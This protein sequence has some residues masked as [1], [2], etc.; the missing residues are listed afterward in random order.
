MIA[1]AI[2]LIVHTV[3]LSDGSRKITQ[4]T[5]VAEMLDEIHINLKDIFI[6]KQTGIDSE[7][8][9]LG[10]FRPTG[11]IPS[12]LEDIKRRN[13]SLSEELFKIR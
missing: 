1:S 6:F 12:F 9:V 7:G 5:E 3:R 11:Y 8:R 10:D 13:I 4:I 2:N